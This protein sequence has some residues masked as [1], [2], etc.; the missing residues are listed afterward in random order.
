MKQ[1][2]T[3]IL[4]T[5]EILLYGIKT[6]MFYIQSSFFVHFLLLLLDLKLSYICMLV[7]T[8]ALI[9]SSTVT[10]LLFLGEITH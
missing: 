8:H 9:R 10:F 1:D 4:D 7:H 3:A 5:H 6:L 2:F